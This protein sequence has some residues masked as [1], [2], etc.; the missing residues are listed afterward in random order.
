MY[1]AGSMSVIS[2][3][4]SP[5]P[6][7]CCYWMGRYIELLNRPRRGIGLAHL[8]QDD[9]HP[10]WSLLEYLCMRKRV[11]L[12]YSVKVIQSCAQWLETLL[13]MVAISNGA[14][15]YIFMLLSFFFFSSPN[16]SG[17]RLDVYHYFHT[18]CGPSVKLECRS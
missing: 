5:S 10:H 2:S 11:K 18:W 7:V 3:N 15:H 6:S 4:R 14:D 16:L 17:R 13:F 8:Y 12:R 9:N 1:A